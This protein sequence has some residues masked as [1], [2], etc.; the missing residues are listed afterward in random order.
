M[1]AP[2]SF[3]VKPFEGKRY[4]NTMSLGG[5]D[6]IVSSSQE[7]H[8]VTNRYAEVVSCP[9]NYNGPVSPGDLLIVHHNVFRVYF[10]MRGRD[11]NGRSFLNEGTFLIDDDQWFGYGREGDWKAKEGF[12]FVRPVPVV[13]DVYKNVASVEPLMGE[14]VFSSDNYKNG[15]IISYIPESDYQ[16]TVDGEL[17]YRLYNSAITIKWNTKKLEKK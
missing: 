16:F 3:I 9:N 10:D 6:F 2:T 14:V 11:R 4:S 17:M 13:S 5:V 1:R 15:D 7:D 12:T 8:I